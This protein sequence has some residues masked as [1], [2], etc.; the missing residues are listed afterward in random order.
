MFFSSIFS[1]IE[2]GF[3]KNENG[4]QKKTE[5]Q[6]DID[7]IPPPGIDSKGIIEEKTDLNHNRQNV[8]DFIQV[9]FDSLDESKCMFRF[10]DRH[11]SSLP[12]SR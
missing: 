1:F 4:Y 9:G 3:D 8:S 11:D 12:I 7:P 10:Y 6:T 2:D 5:I